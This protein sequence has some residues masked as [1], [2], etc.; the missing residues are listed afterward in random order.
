[1]FPKR[2]WTPEEDERLRALVKAQLGP[3]N[4]SDIARYFDQR[5][6]KQ[7]RERW[8]NHLCDNLL[9]TEWSRE[10]DDR[11]IALH[12]A[13]GN[14]WAFLTSY[15]PG[16]TD[17]M[18]KNRWNTT[19]SRRVAASVSSL[20]SPVSLSKDAEQALDTAAELPALHPAIRLPITSLPGTATSLE[21][22]QRDLIPLPTPNHLLPVPSDSFES[23]QPLRYH[24]ALSS[25]TF[26]LRIPVFNRALT[27]LRCRL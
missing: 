12:A 25:P 14:R 19:L 3:F 23:I 21:D 17:N 27:G 16:R 4:W 2:N 26:S 5:V 8:H 20:D 9:K 7:C 11:L 15:F 10:E 1:V 13:H 24:L 18:I 6:G 22:P